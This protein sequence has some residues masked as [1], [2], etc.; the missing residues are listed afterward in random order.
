M[1]VTLRRVVSVSMLAGGLVGA[2]LLAS[3][4]LPLVSS[5]RQARAAAE[6]RACFDCHIDFKIEKFSQIH[7]CEGVSCV[8]CHGT[9]KAHKDDEVRKTLPDAVFRGK[10]MKVFCLTCHRAAEHRKVDAHAAAE[11]KA[12]ETGQ[13][14][15]VC[16]TCHGEHKLMRL[17]APAPQSA[18]PLPPREG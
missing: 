13:P 3:C 9:S 5:G 7:E 18:T 14:E 2:A 11:A 8:R 17:D 16:T 4:R 15:P 1:H 6:S 10:T 12:R